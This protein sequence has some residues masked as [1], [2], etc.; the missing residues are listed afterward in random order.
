MLDLVQADVRGRRHTAEKSLGHEKIERGLGLIPTS[1]TCN[2]LH[3]TLNPPRL[4]YPRS[5]GPLLTFIFSSGTTRLN[6][7]VNIPT[8]MFRT[9][10]RRTS[11]HASRLVQGQRQ[12]SA[13]SIYSSTARPTPHS[14]SKNAAPFLCAHLPRPRHISFAQRLR[15]TYREASKGIFRK[16]P[17]LLPLAIVSVVGGIAIFAYISYVELTRV[18]PQY[19]KFPPP[20]ADSLRTAVY[21]TEID[22]NPPRALKSYKEA[23]Q[24]ALELG[25]HPFSDEVLGIKLQVAMM[26]EKAGLVKPAIAVLERTKNE[27]LSWVEE[28]RN[29][30]STPVGKVKESQAPQAKIAPDNVQIHDGALQDAEKELVAMRE[31]EARQRDRVLKKAVGMEMKLA[32]LYASDHIQDDRKAEA[33]QI[34]A[35]ELC[36]K[37]MHR[38]Q[39]LGLPVGGGSTDDGATSDSWLNMVEIATALA[40][41]AG[42]YT[43]K[44]RYELAMPLYLRALD[45]IRASEADSPSCKQVVLLNDVASAMAGQVQQGARSRGQQKQPVSQ[46]QTVEAARQWAQKSLDVAARIQPP[47]RDEECDLTCVVAT[48][49]LGELAELQKKPSVAKER[50]SEAKSLAQG[51]GYEEGVS[52]A[53]AALKR[54]AKK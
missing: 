33:A 24:I 27:A 7:T 44:E 19:H 45:L 16:N 34:A 48:Y 26:L 42:T 11:A 5:L 25:M 36:L 4:R 10:S 23:L 51:L 22:L 12:S 39:K 47:V 29:A 50:Y 43:A 35:V 54:L 13:R 9:A 52:M 38:R 46:E 17:V 14:K 49:N 32:E 40:E 8:S 20:V 1:Q 3:A 31:F 37:E 2:T 28:S 30:E 6:P 21:Y 15:L 53:D 18:A 41:L